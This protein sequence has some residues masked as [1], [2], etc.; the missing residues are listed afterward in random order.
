[1]NSDVRRERDVAQRDRDRHDQK[2]TNADTHRVQPHNC[3]SH[4][5]VSKL[6]PTHRTRPSLSGSA[7]VIAT[8]IVTGRAKFVRSEFVEKIK[9][10]THWQHQAMVPNQLADGVD[11]TESHCHQSPRGLIPS[12]PE[13]RG[14]S[15][16][17]RPHVRKYCK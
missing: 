12:E 14:R 8:C 11:I 16:V 2:D 1:M 5:P 17:E 10:S 13:R 3:R 4:C 9:Q 7:L 6:G 15:G